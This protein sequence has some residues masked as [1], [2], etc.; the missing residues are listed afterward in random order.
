[1]VTRLATDFLAWG[2][3]GSVGICVIFSY[4]IVGPDPAQVAAPKPPPAPAL[5]VDQID[6]E[7]VT[8]VRDLGRVKTWSL[9]DR[10]VQDQGALNR[11]ESRDARRA[12]WGRVRRLKRLKLIHGVGRNEIAAMKPVRDPARPGPKSGK[13]F[14]LSNNPVR[15][16]GDGM[17][18]VRCSTGT[19]P[20]AR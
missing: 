4:A 11:A 17:D 3:A 20:L 10:L 1:M 7:I 16:P 12:L 8:R 14:D 6:Q 18:A 15:G 13:R 2:S 9:L 19:N 5:P